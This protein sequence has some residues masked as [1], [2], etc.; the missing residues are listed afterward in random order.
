M[1]CTSAPDAVG[2][3]IVLQ[4]KIGADLLASPLGDFRKYKCACVV[5]ALLA[6]TITTLDLLNVRLVEAATKFISEYDQRAISPSDQLSATALPVEAAK[7]VQK[8]ALKVTQLSE[9]G[10]KIT[11]AGRKPC[12]HR[13]RHSSR[14]QRRGC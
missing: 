11:V 1:I 12:G 13:R 9:T 3:L 2:S 5:C 6:L 14:A 7:S 8:P 10:S 4:R